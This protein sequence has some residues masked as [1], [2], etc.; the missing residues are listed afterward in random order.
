MCRDTVLAVVSKLP[1]WRKLAPIPMLWGNPPSSA[2]APAFLS[3][4]PCALC[5]LYNTQPWSD[6]GAGG[7]GITA[8]GGLKQSLKP[9]TLIQVAPSLWHG[10]FPSSI[11]KPLTA[12]GTP[13]SLDCQGSGFWEETRRVFESSALRACFVP[14]SGCCVGLGLSSGS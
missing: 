10:A 13:R 7:A 5:T 4:A 2:L 9:L 14:S 3:R 1:S 11:S 6:V 8:E 12:F